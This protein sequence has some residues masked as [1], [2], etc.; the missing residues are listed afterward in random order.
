MSQK[1]LWIVVGI[2]IVAIAVIVV[3]IVV[4]GGRGGEV[5][6]QQEQ[7]DLEELNAALEQSVQIDVPSANPLDSAPDLNPVGK[8]NPYEGLKTNPF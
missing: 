3:V 7:Q 8:T 4:R 5:D 6:L 1:N 2:V